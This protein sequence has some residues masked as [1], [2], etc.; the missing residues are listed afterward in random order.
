MAER[1]DGWL[2][3]HYIGVSQC[4][5]MVLTTSSVKTPPH[6]ERPRRMF[7]LQRVGVGG[8]RG[9][10]GLE[11]GEENRRKGQKGNRAGLHSQ[12][13]LPKHTHTHTAC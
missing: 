13:R 11:G 4:P 12:R 7:G 2:L 1:S 10:M 5:A 3:G 8:G 9:V 6:P